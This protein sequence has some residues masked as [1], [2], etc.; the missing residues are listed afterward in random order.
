MTGTDTAVGKTLVAGGLV[1]LL[2]GRGVDAVGW[3]PVATGV[4][5]D[6][7]AAF[8]AAAADGAE[9]R[10]VVGPLRFRDPL[11]PA[12]AAARE[13]RTVDAPALRAAFGALRA[14]HGFVVV[15]GVGG[16]LVPLT[17]RWSVADLAADLAL[18]L[19][20]VARAGLGTLNHVALTVEAAERRGL[21]VLG[22]VLCRETGGEPGLAERTNPAALADLVPVPVLGT[23]PRLAPAAAADPGGV[24]AALAESLDLRSVLAEA[25][26]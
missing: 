21:R 19:L 15:E 7:D 24:A 17:R 16:L 13:G 20:V 8:L 10:D 3:K 9:P 11:A 14:R 26:A 6:D 5:P 2:R 23:L 25:G 12:V 1:R 18:P 22:I 4:G